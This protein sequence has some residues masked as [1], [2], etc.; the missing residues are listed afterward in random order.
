MLIIYSAL[1]AR[2][3]LAFEMAEGTA[4][5]AKKTN[6]DI[7]DFSDVKSQL[8]ARP[9]NFDCCFTARDQIWLEKTLAEEMR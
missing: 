9:K 5:G 8:V 1:L 4:P 6:I 2:L 3:V 7:L